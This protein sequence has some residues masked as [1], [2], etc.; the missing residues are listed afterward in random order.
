MGNIVTEE[1]WVKYGLRG[2]GRQILQGQWAGTCPFTC[3][4]LETW[5]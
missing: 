5:W 3:E 2:T 4:E 1:G